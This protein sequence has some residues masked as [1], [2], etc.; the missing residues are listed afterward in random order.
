MPVES[1]YVLGGRLPATCMQHT[2]RSLEIDIFRGL[3]LIFIVVDHISGGVLAWTTLRNFAIADATEVFVF[4]AGV[5]TVMAYGNIAARR[6]VEEADRRF[7][8][9]SG[10]IYRA[11]VV[12]ALLMFACG[13]LLLW[14]QLDTPSLGSSQV[15]AFVAAPWRSLWEVITL[16]RQPFLSDILP[17][18]AFFA[19]LAPLA[20]RLARYSWVQLLSV[21][22]GIWLLAPWF[23]QYLPSVTMPHWAFNPLGWQLV[24]VLGLIAGMYPTLP[25]RPAAPVRRFITVAACV[26]ALLAAVFSLFSY[27]QAIREIFLPMWFEKGI[28]TFS[29]PNASAVR[30]ASFLAIA[31][32]MYGVVRRGWLQPLFRRMQPVAV[33]GR[34]GLVCFVGGA[35]ISILA[36]ALS[37]RLSG[38]QPVWPY[39][40]LVDLC[41]LAAL[42]ALAYGWEAGRKRVRAAAQRK[43]SAALASPATV[44]LTPL[45]ARIPAPAT[46]N[47]SR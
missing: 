28:A 9:R 47:R 30:I 6:G 22:V 5:V 3:A 7:L 24:F 33:V 19:L 23:G 46:R 12:T 2:Q 31:W 20:I 10:E 35:V 13:A 25:E 43:S 41:A 18:Y 16:Q 45:A 1:V 39:N 38:G 29:K 44:M 21:S 15:K 32:L 14:W 40:L 34:N 26:V 17:M 11:F 27:H 37:F 36:E 42:F 4:L 8:R